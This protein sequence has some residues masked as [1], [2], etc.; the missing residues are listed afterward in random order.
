MRQKADRQTERKANRQMNSSTE[1]RQADRYSIG[2]VFRKIE[3]A[4]KQSKLL[5]TIPIK[6]YTKKLVKEGKTK[7]ERTTVRQTVSYKAF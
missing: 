3:T 6:S 7:E 2:T 1:N 4:S 5:A